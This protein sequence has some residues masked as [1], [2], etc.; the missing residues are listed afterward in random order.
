MINVPTHKSVA[1]FFLCNTK[2]VIA[3]M[4]TLHF[5][6]HWKTACWYLHFCLL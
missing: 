5:S 1:P 4:P 3:K 6:T 2:R